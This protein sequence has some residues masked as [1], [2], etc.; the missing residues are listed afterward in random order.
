M[1]TRGLVVDKMKFSRENI[2]MALDTLRSHKLRSFL[3]VLGV[4]IGTM[5]VIIIAALVSGIDARVAK[6]IQSFGTNSIYIYKFDPGFNFA[7]SFEERSRKP[8][9]LEDALAIQNECK[10]ISAV[11]AL[12][13]PVDFTQ[14]PLAERVHVKVRDV[15]MSNAT[16]QGVLPAYFRMGALEIAEGREFNEQDNN[17]D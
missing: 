15:Q 12:V 8:L 1:G 6:E 4:I 11:T 14:G 10:S 5:T 7:P 2:W 16:V 13:S 3:T 9:S 17:N